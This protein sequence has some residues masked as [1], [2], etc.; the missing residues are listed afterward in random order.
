MANVNNRGNF[1]DWK[2]G[3]PPE[4]NSHFHGGGGNT[5]L[6]QIF[7]LFLISNW[8]GPHF[9]S[10]GKKIPKYENSFTCL[11]SS[12]LWNMKTPLLVGLFH[13]SMS[14]G[15]LQNFFFFKREGNYL[16]FLVVYSQAFP[17][18]IFWRKISPAQSKTGILKLTEWGTY[19]CCTSAVRLIKMSQKIFLI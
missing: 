13:H 16:R 14:T 9:R 19:Q 17:S 3:Q 15:T 6:A 10:D 1:L 8:C 12:P 5:L 2:P 11:I 4:C 7:A 18:R